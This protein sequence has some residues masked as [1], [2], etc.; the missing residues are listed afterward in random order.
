MNII[1]QD[2][3]TIQTI[4]DFDARFYRK[5][6]PEA[7]ANPASPLE[8]F[9]HGGAAQGRGPR[10]DFDVRLYVAKHPIVAAASINPYADYLRAQK[11]SA[12]EVAADRRIIEESGRF[13]P[14]FYTTQVR[15][16][17]EDVALEHFLREGADRLLDPNA[18]FSVRHYVSAFPETRLTLVNPFA[19]FLIRTLGCSINSLDSRGPV[20]D[21]ETLKLAA[22]AQSAKFDHRP[23]DVIVPIYGAERSVAQCVHSLL[24]ANTA[25]PYQI[26]LIDDASPSPR[27]AAL[28]EKLSSNDKIRVIVRPR[29]SGFV[30][31]VNLGFEQTT[32]D[33]VI[34]NSDTAVTDGWL[35]RLQV[36]AYSQVRVASVTPFTNN[37]TI[38]SFPE[39]FSDGDISSVDRD[40]FARHLA[41][42]NAGNTLEVPTGHGFCMYVRRDALSAVGSFDEHTFGRG[43]G[44][45]NDFCQRAIELGWVNLHALDAFVYHKGSA[46]FGAYNAELN[47]RE[48]ELVQKKHPTYLAQVAGY[49][50]L[51][52][53]GPARLR[54]MLSLALSRDAVATVA[55][56][57]GS[58][59]PS[60]SA[61]PHV[62]I[63][64]DQGAGVLHLEIEYL[65]YRPHIALSG[66][67]TAL[68]EVLAELEGLNW[69][70]SAVCLGYADSLEAVANAGIPL[71]VELEDYSL[72]CSRKRM[73][74]SRGEPCGSDFDSGCNRCLVSQSE[75]ATVST[76]GWSNRHAWIDSD[77]VTLETSDPLIQ[78]EMQRH[79]LKVDVVWA[80]RARCNARTDRR[81][82]TTGSALSVFVEIGAE[83][84]D[85]L[86][87]KELL[88]ASACSAVKCTFFLEHVSPEIAAF[89]L[90]VGVGV[91]E[92]R[93]WVSWFCPYAGFDVVVDLSRWLHTPVV[94]EHLGHLSDVMLVLPRST[95]QVTG[96]P[97]N[98]V[99]Y[100]RTTT[101]AGVFRKVLSQLSRGFPATKVENPAESVRRT[102]PSL[103]P[104][105]NLK[106]I[107]VVPDTYS[108]MT[109]PCGWIR[110]L[111]PLR[112][113]AARL[114]ADLVIGDI[115]DLHSSEH[116]LVITN[117]LAL[118]G[119]GE[120]SL[121]RLRNS[122][123]PVIYDIDD[124]LFSLG[125]GHPDAAEVRHKRQTVQEMLELS[126][127]VTTSTEVLRQRISKSVPSSTPVVVVP[128]GIDAASWLIKR[129][130]L[131]SSDV[132]RILYCGTQS[133][134]ADWAAVRREIVLTAEFARRPVEIVLIGV[135]DDPS[136]E[137]SGHLR[138]LSVPDRLEYPQFV[139]WILEQ[140][141]FH[142]GIAPLND[143]VFNKAKSDIKYLE[144]SA[145]GLATVA[146]RV[147]PY[148]STIRHGIDGLLASNVQEFGEMVSYLI[149]CPRD[150]DQ[151]AARATARLRRERTLDSMSQHWVRIL[152]NLD[153]REF[154]PMLA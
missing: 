98:I 128:N 141:R 15:G 5:R 14:L 150:R 144:Y 114:G 16:I 75:V 149:Q 56:S 20:F 88:E 86:V 152:S 58:S 131:N 41:I 28:L 129:P 134:A 100:E 97:D 139:E 7:R 77:L 111:Q 19:D 153:S 117:R 101:G 60:S 68:A 69:A 23:V 59:E 70:G 9:L 122:G 130:Q 2:R 45:E 107:L 42:A 52:P 25:V 36:A 151:I 33:V 38:F 53:A 71:R 17:T 104:T 147:A 32:H 34:L 67:N 92:C 13:D 116:D 66:S 135:P 90:E 118:F 63:Y 22:R 3:Q 65:Q 142:I 154:V 95:T 73:T 146:S 8:D 61:E 148:A 103:D 84:G 31:T 113:A 50:G 136:A 102:Y 62:L 112:I 106:S 43:Y 44:E 119:A 39:P 109:S 47:G 127:V 18:Y 82:A 126:A 89:A 72:L 140:E 55:W 145:L 48:V 51:D 132:T 4:G 64:F 143:S 93:P 81:R 108:G 54:A 1:D 21:M 37:G 11:R 110:L 24:S 27:I 133:H 87:L 121:R 78:Q 125:A 26:L 83:K 120:G 91:Q 137:Q 49:C 99:E 30:S 10:V 12:S 74:N 40:E 57:C 85:L 94:L 138:V 35:D 123:T 105:A 46:S 124:D 80:D 76:S 79:G 96:S 29:N 6:Y 115:D